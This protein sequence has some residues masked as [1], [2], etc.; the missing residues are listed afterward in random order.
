MYRFIKYMEV[1]KN[2]KK[3]EDVMNAD[4]IHGENIQKTLTIN[5]LFNGLIILLFGFS[6]SLIGFL[7]EVFLKIAINI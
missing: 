4:L 7:F 6:V 3:K 1:I 2:V 5:D